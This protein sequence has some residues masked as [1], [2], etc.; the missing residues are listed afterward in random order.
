MFPLLAQLIFHAPK[1]DWQYIDNKYWQIVSMESSSKD[2]SLGHCPPGMIFIDGN[3]LEDSKIP[4]NIS[5]LQNT[6]CDKCISNLF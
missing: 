6:V 4:D 2:M 1:H 5:S 3:M